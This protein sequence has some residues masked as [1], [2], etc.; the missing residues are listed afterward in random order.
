MF[1]DASDS[2]PEL[3]LS[4]NYFIACDSIFANAFHAVIN[5]FLCL[6]YPCQ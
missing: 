6:F 3:L 4:R 1:R 5:Q 2:I